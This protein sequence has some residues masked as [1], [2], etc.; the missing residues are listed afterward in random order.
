M[1][2]TLKVSSVGLQTV[3][4]PEMVVEDITDFYKFTK[5]SF[6]LKNYKYHDFDE[7]IEVAI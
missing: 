5:N 3:T 2:A 7:K 4:A 1:M 6:T